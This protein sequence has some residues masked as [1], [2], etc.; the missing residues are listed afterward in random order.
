M[1][2]IAHP[3]N[4]HNLLIYDQVFEDHINRVTK[5]IKKFISHHSG[6]SNVKFHIKNKLVKI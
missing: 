1:Q 6:A 5:D 3:Y 2:H 4:V